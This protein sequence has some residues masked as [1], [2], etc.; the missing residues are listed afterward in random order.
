MSP[1]ITSFW[2][3]DS[4][5]PNLGFGVTA[6]STEDAVHLLRQAGIE[7]DTDFT[8]LMIHENISISDLD[9]NHVIPNMGPMN[10]RGVW[11]PC[12]NL[13]ATSR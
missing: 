9:Q 7:L 8:K 10:F 13:S 5:T 12:L 11:F 6:F 4:S 1:P 2:I 3:K